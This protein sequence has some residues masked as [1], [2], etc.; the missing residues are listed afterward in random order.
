MIVVAVLN[1]KGGVGKT[2]L[3]THIA[4]A[5]QLSGENVLLVDSDPQGSARDWHAMSGEG[6]DLPPLVA[7]D[8]AALLADVKRIGK[9]YSWVVIDGA[10]QAS[11]LSIA[12]IK[13]ADI[14]LIPV[15][16][17]PYDI[18]AAD[19][20]V[21][22]V[23]ARQEIANGQPKAAFI[24]SRQI[25]GTKIAG[26]ARHA[27]EGYG[28][29]IFESATCQRVSY[30]NTASTGKTVLDVPSDVA[31][32]QEIRALIAELKRYASK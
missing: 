22:T 25:A 1:E 5:L 28:L 19:S 11:D 2:T 3:S 32:I 24:I 23:K 15:Q 14:V 10:P 16:P 21:Q 31:A 9:S 13:N 20:L 18:W 29:P 12:A 8:R 7:L 26:E 4:R 30:A 17:S 6:S 27:L